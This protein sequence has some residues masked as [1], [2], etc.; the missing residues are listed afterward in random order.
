M[1]IFDPD[2]SKAIKTMKLDEIYRYLL[3]NWAKTGGYLCPRLKRKVDR[4]LNDP[5]ATETDYAEMIG[6]I[7]R[8]GGPTIGRPAGSIETNGPTE[9]RTAEN[10]CGSEMNQE[11]RQYVTLDQ[12]ASLVNRSKRTLEGYKK[13]MPPPAI[14]GGG[15][16]KADEWIWSVLRPWLEKTFD[17]ALPERFPSL[18][19]T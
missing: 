16:G 5:D 7:N 18:K 2:H 14:Q 1:L 13:Q 6:E 11:V 3:R 15:R 8:S 9:R 12:V 17:R 19:R 4:L 10:A